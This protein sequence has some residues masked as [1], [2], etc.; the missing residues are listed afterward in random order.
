MCIIHERQYFE[1]NRGGIIMNKQ[2]QALCEYFGITGEY[3]QDDSVLVNICIVKLKKNHVDKK[4]L[5]T[6]NIETYKMATEQWSSFIE[7]K[8]EPYIFE[9]KDSTADGAIIKALVKVM[10]YEKSLASV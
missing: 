2:L 7:L 9:G 10:N 4:G 5:T 3:D 6:V 1:N 8:S